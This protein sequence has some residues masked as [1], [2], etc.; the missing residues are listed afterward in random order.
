M[1][2]ESSRVVTR[3]WGGMKR[4]SL[5]VGQRARGVPIR[6]SNRG[7]GLPVPPARLL[8]TIGASD[9]VDWFLKSGRLAAVGVQDVLAKNGLDLQHFGNVLDFGCGVGRVLRHWTDLVRIGVS[10]HGTDQNPEL[11]DW[12]RKHLPFASFGVNRLDGRLD[13]PDDTF[14]LISAF[15]VFTH[16]SED[17]QLHW[18]AE[19]RRVLRPGGHLIFSL[20]GAAYRMQLAPQDRQAFDHG[21]LIVLGDSEAS[22]GSNACAAFHP[23]AYVQSTLSRGW[24][25]IDFLREGALGNPHQD[26]Y[27]LRKP[28]VE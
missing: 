9:D 17:R 15:S 2:D 26:L 7:Q 5:R 14:D 27:L 3:A 24:E 19:L 1:R 6:L 25:I 4:W 12:C 20:H 23:E 18:M 11:I 21:A 10:L 8:H 28:T 22:E 13:H 16:L